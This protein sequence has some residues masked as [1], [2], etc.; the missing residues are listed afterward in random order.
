P[1][2]E[3][4]GRLKLAQAIASP[5]N[6]LT[7]RVLVNRVWQHHFGAPLVP[8]P[9]DFGTRGEPPSHPGLLDYVASRF[10]AEGWSVKS[11]H[12]LILGSSVYQQASADNP[13]QRRADPE[14]RWLWR[15][16]RRRLDF[17]SLRDTLLAVTGGLEPTPG[18]PAVPLF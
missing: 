18:G 12:R 4:S 14:N 9:S 6:P 1:F 16:N 8:T 13:D 5:A 11:L 10:M 3:G 15:M 17:E 7:A 2:T